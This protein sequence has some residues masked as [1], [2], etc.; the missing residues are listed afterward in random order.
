MQTQSEKTITKKASNFIASVVVPKLKNVF[1]LQGVQVNKKRWG[2][3]QANNTYTGLF[4]YI[5]FFLN[6]KEDRVY[7][8]QQVFE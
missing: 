4:K 1:Y 5:I 6:F 8:A 3:F 2:Q 7:D